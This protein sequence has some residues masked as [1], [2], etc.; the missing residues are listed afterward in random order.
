MNTAP[1]G[2]PRCGSPID[3]LKAQLS[4]YYQIASA[5]GFPYVATSSLAYNQPIAQPPGVLPQLYEAPV[6]PGVDR[7]SSATNSLENTKDHVDVVALTVDYD[8]GFATMTLSSS[9]AHH[10]NQTNSDLTALYTNF[11]F[12]KPYYGENPRSFIQGH[13]VLDDKLYAEELRFASKTGGMFDWI[14]GLFYKDENS[15]IQEHEFYPGYNDYYNACIAANPNGN[16]GLGE[17]VNQASSIVGIPLVV[18]QAYIGDFETHFKDLAAFGEL[19][20]HITSAWSLT[21]GARVFKQTLDQSQQTG[22]LFDGPGYAANESLSDQWRRAQFKVNS[23]YQLDKNNLVYATWSQG[24]RRGGVNALP[25]SEPFIDPSTGKPYVTPAALT[26]LQPDTADNYEV[27][28]KGTVA[29]RVRYSAAIYDIQWHNIQEGVQLTP[30]VL[31]ASLN[32]GEA[33]S[34]GVELELSAVCDAAPVR[35][36]RLYLRPDQAHLHQSAVHVPECLRAAAGH[37]QPVAGHSEVEPRGGLRVRERAARRGTAALRAQW[38]LPKP[39]RTGALGDGADGALLCHARYPVELGPIALHRHPLR[40]QSHQQSRHLLVYRPLHFRQPLSSGGIDAAHGGIHVGLFVQGAVNGA[41]AVMIRTGG[42]YLDSI[43]D[44]REVYINGERVKNVVK[45]PMLKPL[46]DIR[47]RIYDMQHET[48]TRALLAYQQDGE[49]NAIANKLP[50]TQSDWW[51]KRR[52]TDTILDAIGGV[53]TRVGDETVG[54]MWSLFDGQAVLDEVDPQ[55]SA[56][57]RS[58]INAVLERDPFHV[59]ANT[60]P[61][62]DRSKPPQEQ[63]PDMLLHVVKETDAGIVVRGAKYETAAPYANQAFVKPTI[64]NWGNSALSDYAVGFICDLSSANLK[65]ICRTGFAGRA[66]AA[67]YPLTN[68]FDEIDALVI[69][70]D[71]LVPWENVLFYRHTKAAA[72]IRSTVHRYSAFAFVQ[73]ILRFADLMIG[74]ALFNA[75]QTGLDKQQAVQEK[76][77]QLAVYR[78]GIN[79]HLTASIAMAEKSPAG[80]MMPNQ[81]L[82]YTGRV[83]ACSQLHHMMHL[84]RELCG[85][86]ICVTP[87]KAAFD[88]PDTRPWLEKFYSVNAKWVAEDRRKLLAFA[89][90][91]LNSDY[92]GHRLT[93]QLFAQAP[94]FAHL[95]AVYHNFDWDGPLDFVRRSADLSDRVM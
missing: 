19:T 15:Y 24:F 64:A 81:S 12:Y 83:L 25:P 20:W 72:F 76:L 67:D 89:R 87:D 92:A 47:A 73:R 49:W 86:Q 91:L 58:H 1:P 70:D 54:E 10:N 45:H 88:S 80:L 40:Q 22:L 38:A 43:S 6:P 95:A 93:F 41:C 31:P 30:L 56:N 5:G 75:R 74:A 21:G 28:A 18:D 71:V 23:A 60:D 37:R 53:V 16:C 51:D 2:C 46:I 90:D 63:D 82:L 68:R 79:A 33:Y 50:R 77:A 4:Y 94:P 27:G 9:A 66:P 39:G 29:N 85:G 7:L 57:I 84:A 8:L 35:A 36:T 44:G 3:E 55:F 32:I 59:S 78:E 48:A 52:A 14:G 62:G 69:F 65:F 42:E 26:H 61:K 13:D 11:S 17:Y 34:R